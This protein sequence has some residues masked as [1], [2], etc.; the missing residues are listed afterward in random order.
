MGEVMTVAERLARIAHLKSNTPLTDDV[1]HSARRCIIDWTCVALAGSNQKQALALERALADELG[2]GP[3]RTL[4]GHPSS[5]RTAALINGLASHIVEFDDIYSPGTYHPG[6]PTIAAA[7]SATT[8]LNRS[9]LDLIRAV[10]AGY[11]VSNRVARAMGTDHY[12][13]WH[14]TGTVGSI[15]ATAAVSCIYGLTEVQTAH[16]LATST[17]MAAGLQNAFR[18]TSEIK[19]LHAGHAADTAFVAAGLARESVVAAHDMFEADA[20]FGN[21][22]SGNVEWDNATGNDS[23]AE[24]T[25]ERMTIKNHGC[26]GHIFPAL[27]GALVLQAQHRFAAQDIATIVIGGYSATVD[28]TGNHLADSPAAAKFCLPF[29]VASGLVYGSIRLDAY[30]PERLHDPVVLTLMKNIR[31]ELDA[32]IDARFPS[33]RSANVSITLKDGTELHRFQPHRV[34]DPDLPLTD[35]QLNQKFMELTSRI[36]S[37]EQATD[38]LKKLW[39]LDDKT[40]MDFYF[41]K[42]SMEIR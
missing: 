28:V 26:C 3:S 35:D 30:T 40:D 6:S 17:T 8:G 7:L 1:V 16:A 32:A 29:I 9:G 21:A 22:M 31:V 38:L 13:Y 18:G 25:I 27:D 34:G 37:D 19:P 42:R 39:V 23:L 20:G 5:M 41:L 33:Q 10:I 11:E 15:G 4:T 12:R 24:N 2:Q 14:T 36:L